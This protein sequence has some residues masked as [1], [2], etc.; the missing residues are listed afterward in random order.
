MGD[1]TSVHWESSVQRFMGVLRGNTFMGGCSALVE[2]NAPATPF[3]VVRLSLSII[4]FILLS[5]VRDAY[6]RHTN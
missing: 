1:V 4:I 3:I 6:S 5:V 2:D